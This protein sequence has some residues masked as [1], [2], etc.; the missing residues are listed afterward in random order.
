MVPQRSVRPLSE[1]GHSTAGDADGAL[2]GMWSCSKTLESLLLLVLEH[3]PRGPTRRLPRWLEWLAQV[4]PVDWMRC[5]SD[6]R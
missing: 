5:D 4:G 1:S 2:P 3:L 6:T